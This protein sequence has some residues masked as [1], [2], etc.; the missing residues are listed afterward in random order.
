MSLRHHTDQSGEPMARGKISLACSIHR[1][2]IFLFL[3]ADQ[4]LHI[5][6]TVYI[7][8]SDCI[9]IVHK[10]PL[11]PNSAVNETF[12]HNSGVE[13]SV[14]WIFII[15]AV[16]WW[17]MG[18]FVTLDKICDSVLFEQEVEATPFTFKFSSLTHSPEK[19]FIRNIIIILWVYSTII[20]IIHIIN[21]NAI[22]NNNCGMLKDFIL[23][24][25]IPK[26]TRKNF[27]KINWKFGHAPSKRFASPC[28]V[29][30]HSTW[31]RPQH[32]T[33]IY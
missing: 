30:H 22:I 9:D 8:I 18:E 5:E 33:E 3:L 26:G 28:I 4:Q 14:D 23:L 17:S 25:K 10:L 24:F 29:P 27:F 6:K 19:A 11:L 31:S 2:P 12:L 21:N 16:H 7:H 15:G 32:V 20:I 13:W 1:C